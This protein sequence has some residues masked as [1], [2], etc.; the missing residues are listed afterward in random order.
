MK[1]ASSPTILLTSALLSVFGVCG[2][3][4]AETPDKTYKNSIGMEFVP[5]PAGRF[6]MGCS[7]E[8]EPC[9][10]GEKPRHE[11][12]ISK[13]FYLGK[14]EVTQAQWE[15]VM[16]N[17]PSHYKG[18]NRP[19]ELVSW[20]DVQEFI[21]RLNAKEGHTRYRLPTEAEWEYAA[22]AGSTTAYS[23]GND[24]SQLERY[25]WYDANSGR[26]T[27]PVGEKEANKWGLHD[28]HGNVWEW[29]QDWEGGY[30]AAAATNPQGPGTGE[31]RVLRGGSKGDP[32][33]SARC[34]KRLG[35]MPWFSNFSFGFRLALDPAE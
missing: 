26:Q 13:P 18:A 17:N 30:S 5:I 35:M 27:H 28:M 21:R 15:A 7:T 31:N 16:G 2:L 23:F 33:S 22:R 19:V 1:R 34:A 14:Y 24:M 11:V 9:E 20:D 3:C 32:A 4:A 25:A 29:V 6:L 10:A 8:A 12:T